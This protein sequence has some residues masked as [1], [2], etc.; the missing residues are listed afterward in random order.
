MHWGIKI[1]IFYGGFVVVVLAS[2]FFAMTQRVNLV[3]DNYYEKELKYQ[4]QIDKSQRTKTLKEKTN[5]QLLERQVKIKLPALPDKNNPKDYILFYRPSDP[6]KDFKVA[7]AS[8]SLGFQT[9]SI[10]KLSKGFWKIKLN[11][12]SGGV[13]YYDEGMINIP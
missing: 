6:S 4:E 2:V 1:A 5:I 10:E 8:D 7:I 3:S 12:T 11:W 13:E 9:V